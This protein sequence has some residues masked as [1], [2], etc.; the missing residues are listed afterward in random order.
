MTHQM[1]GDLA[2]IPPALSTRKH[3]GSELKLTGAAV[4]P[5]ESSNPQLC[6]ST[7]KDTPRHLA[8]P[9]RSSFVMR[10]GSTSACCMSIRRAVATRQSWE[11]LDAAARSAN[12]R[13]R[14]S[15]GMFHGTKTSICDVGTCCIERKGISKANRFFEPAYLSKK[16]RT[17]PQTH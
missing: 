8:T 9:M 11:G 10:F 13:G 4:D 14:G 5:N 7:A 3:L 1:K 17:E 2:V 16:R 15:F 12:A 6:H